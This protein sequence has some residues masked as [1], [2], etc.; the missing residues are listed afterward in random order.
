MCKKLR[1][2]GRRL[3]PCLKPIIKKINR[4][5]IWKTLASCCGHGKY[6]LSIIAKNQQGEIYEIISGLHLKKP[7]RHRFY[8]R[9]DEGYYYLN[10]DLIMS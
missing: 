3:D 7:K 10:A 4:A 6:L 5:G 9:D 8:K 1:Y 2:G